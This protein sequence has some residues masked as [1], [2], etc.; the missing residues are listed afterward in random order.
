[1]KALLNKSDFIGLEER[2]NLCAGG[3]TPM[4]KS[5]FGAMNQ[6]ALDKSQGERA[7]DLEAQKVESA[8]MKCGRLFGVEKDD[9]TF[10]SSASEGINNVA[11]GLKWKMGDNVV[12]VDVEFPSGILPWTRLCSQGVEVRIV[13]HKN[14]FIDIEDIAAQIDDRTRVV[15][16]SHVSMFTG[17]R[18][19]VSSISQLVR[20]SNALFLRD[21]THAAGGSSGGC[22]PC[23]YHGK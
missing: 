20:S 6:F 13:R 12:I 5:H 4:L 15:A 11:H 9:I 8:R 19:D 23:G 10:L 7:R 17:Q 2:V 18:M 14:W 21:A 22:K 16:L 1:M 3:E